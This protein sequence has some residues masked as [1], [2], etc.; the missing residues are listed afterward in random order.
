MGAMIDFN[1]GSSP[2]IPIVAA[3]PSPFPSPLSLTQLSLSLSLLSLI[4][5][6]EMVEPRN[7]EGF[8]WVF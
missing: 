3:A 6:A 5:T 8:L 1:C 7:V 4:Q 2:W